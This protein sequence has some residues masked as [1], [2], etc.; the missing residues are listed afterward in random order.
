M[1]VGSAPV[2][3]EWHKATHFLDR[4]NRPE[5][6]MRKGQDLAGSVWLLKERLAEAKFLEGSRESS[7]T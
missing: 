3:P 4:D 7:R 2:S 5:E 6:L 1:S